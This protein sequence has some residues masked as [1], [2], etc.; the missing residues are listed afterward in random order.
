MSASMQ[1]LRARTP[2]LLVLPS[3]ILILGIAIYPII[4]AFYT[5]LTDRN[6]M[7]QEYSF[8]FLG[9]YRGRRG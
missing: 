4:F 9:N 3:I 7:S 1:R 8:I 5:S 6:L 2:A